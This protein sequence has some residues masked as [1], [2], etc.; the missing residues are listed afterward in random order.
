MALKIDV[1]PEIGQTIIKG[2]L[3]E[4]A[5]R[6]GM[7]PSVLS[8]IFINS[9]KLSI[10]C[11]ENDGVLCGGGKQAKIIILGKAFSKKADN[12]NLKIKE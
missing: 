10:T 3:D 7:S 4:V 5:K 1:R 8:D 6:F 11:D 12:K 9:C 2:P